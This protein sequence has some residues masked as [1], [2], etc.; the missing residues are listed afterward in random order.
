MQILTRY[1]GF[2][3]VRGAQRPEAT[4]NKQQR[5]KEKDTPTWAQQEKPKTTRFPKERQEESNLPK[6]TKEEVRPP[7][8]ENE[9]KTSPPAVEDEGSRVLGELVVG[10][11]VLRNSSQTFLL[12][13]GAAASILS[14]GTVKK[15]FPRNTKLGKWTGDALQSFH[16]TF[17]IK[18]ELNCEV[19]LG[20][21]NFP[22]R[23]CIVKEETEAVLG[24]NFIK[25]YQV[26][27]EWDRD[28]YKATL[29][30][31]N[32]EI[33][34][35]ATQ[36]LR[37][38]ASATIKPG[39][40]VYIDCNAATKS[41]QPNTEILIEPSKFTRGALR[42]MSGVTYTQSDNTIQTFIANFGPVPIQIQKGALIGHVSRTEIAKDRI[43]TSTGVKGITSH[44]SY[45]E[46]KKQPNPKE[47]VENAIIGDWLTKEEKEKVKIFLRKR[48]K[49]FAFNPKAPAT[50]AG[51]P[52]SINTGNAK[53]F[54]EPVRRA[55]PNKAQE[56]ARQVKEMLDDGVISKSSSPWSSP[57]CLAKK[58]D[59]TWRFCIDYRGL[60]RVT[61]KDAY[62]LPPIDAILDALGIKSARIWT[63]L[64]AAS[65]FWQIH[66]IDEDKEKTAFTT[67]YGHYE[68]N[69][70][71]FGL[72]GAPAA[73]CRA[74]DD[75]LRD[76]LWKVCLVFVDD[77]V[78]WGESFEDHLHNLKMVFNALDKD[79]FTLKL[80]KC[81]FFMKEIRFLGHVV[82]EGVIKMDPEKI[83]AIVEMAP[84]TNLKQLQSF[85]GMTAWYQKF[86]QGYHI[87]AQPLEAKL[88]KNNATPWTID[89]PDTDQ[90]KAFIKLKQSIQEYPIRRLPDW[91]KTFFVIT[92]ASDA[93]CG[94]IL[95]QEHD[96][97]ELPIA[98]YSSA[99]KPAEKSVHSYV[100]ETR[101]LV[102]ALKHFK[103]YLWGV[104][105]KVITDCRALAHWNEVK[106]VPAMVERYLSFITS[107]DF[108]LIHRAGKLIP[109]SDALSRN[110]LVNGRKEWKCSNKPP[111][112]KANNPGIHAAMVLAVSALDIR[113]AQEKDRETQKIS[114]YLET[115]KFPEKASKEEQTAIAKVSQNLYISNGLLLRRREPDKGF[116]NPRIYVPEGPPRNH[117]LK[118]L[119]DDHLAGHLGAKRTFLRIAIRFWWPEMLEEVT[120]YV[121]K[122]MVCNTNKPKPTSK[123]KL[124]P[125]AISGPWFNVH[126]DYMEMPRK[127]KDSCTHLLVMI[128]RFTKC[129]ELKPVNQENAKETAEAF[130]DEVILRHGCPV[131][132]TTDGGTPFKGEF[133]KLIKEYQISH[134]KGLPN[135]HR[136]NGQA[137]RII[138]SIR[139]YLRHY[140]TDDDWSSCITKCRFALNSAVT[141][142]HGK[143]PYM[144]DT[145]REP[146]IPLDNLLNTPVDVQAT[147]EVTEEASK[148][149]TENQEK[150][151]ERY[152]KDATN[153]KHNTG[154]LVFIRNHKPK[155]KTDSKNFGPYRV[156][157]TDKEITPNILLENPWV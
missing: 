42:T 84:P 11:K 123:A 149:L 39:Q 151:K 80:S 125:M 55:N 34:I 3:S 27:R 58:S 7:S 114:T 53:P 56:I 94:A 47:S 60:N 107:H 43:N 13:T 116:G 133:K 15:M 118:Y 93:G 150:M 48:R 152:D 6:E 98:F 106:E 101:A 82:S 99:W 37:T 154:A 77:I 29:G 85:L 51:P 63:T 105:F 127:S 21:Y 28:R 86:I 78:V 14:E 108:A 131:S 126:L 30:E 8:A 44:Q 141:S 136:T 57:V 38:I 40:G 61:K 90:G 24:Y 153:P 137:E 134:D 41:F 35:F 155:S 96:G 76:L 12:D 87:V 117:I 68:F 22:I 157:Q 124:R 5:Q 10:N 36:Q 9:I 143:S 74:M 73:F 109:T 89:K 66:I 148:K 147:T 102:K 75:T 111:L 69:V 65:G 54:K 130:H 129:I 46:F 135:R 120:T 26:Q 52:A 19:K 25:F 32:I 88:G 18:G 122:C 142:A 110:L 4:S 50:Y 62:P 64:D 16:N 81:R 113:L 128:D 91:N 79:G 138:R 115:G 144:V 146:R 72:H 49:T 67:L 112:T 70:V 92:D 95:A 20:G 71:P 2:K 139:E 45:T 132:I 156:A 121:G 145:G 17:E 119:H 97:F 100:K 83:K 104:R 103:H 23:F 33:P 140:A 1:Q 59:G 31:M